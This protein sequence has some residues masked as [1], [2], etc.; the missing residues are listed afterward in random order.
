M[1]MS[2]PTRQTARLLPLRTAWFHILLALADG[3]QHGYGIRA[4]VDERSGIQLWPATLYGTIRKLTE[5]G[6]I[7]ELEGAEDDDAR[8]RYYQLTAFGRDVLGAEA[9]RLQSL[10]DAA[11]SSRALGST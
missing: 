9:D 4:L 8:R 7:E 11:R 2:E 1:S 5:A 3:P 10:V 6:L